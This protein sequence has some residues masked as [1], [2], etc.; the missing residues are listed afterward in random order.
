MCSQ[1]GATKAQLKKARWMRNAILP[2][3]SWMGEGVGKDVRQA[4][5][6]LEPSARQND[7][8]GLCSLA[9][10]YRLGQAGEV[11]PQ[12]SMRLYLQVAMQGDEES[13]W[14]HQALMPALVP[15]SAGLP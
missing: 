3:R 12:L 15:A 2:K 5:R 8:D 1:L 7:V 13:Q 4:K 9:T 10:L 14:W 11:N 6:Y